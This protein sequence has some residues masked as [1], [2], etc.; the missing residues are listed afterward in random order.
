MLVIP[1]LELESGALARGSAVGAPGSRD[2]VTAARAWAA[3][4]Y[5]RLLV[6]DRD[7]LAGRRPNYSLIETL[8]RD[9]GVEVDVAGGVDSADQIEAWIDCG[10]VRVV[11]GARALADDDWLRSTVEAFPRIL[12][13]ETNVRERRVTTRGWVRALS[14]DLRDLVDDLSGVPIAALIVTAPPPPG[15]A[16]ELALLEDV[17]EASSFPV[18]VEDSHPSI[19]ALR[20]FEHRGVAGVVVPAAPLMTALDPRAVANEFAR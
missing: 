8:T 13:V 6:V 20:A 16:T 17:A 14:I 18:L 10:A 5:G 2:P 4:G 15:N 9:A 1:K 7:A 19:R 12:M 3:E 11:L